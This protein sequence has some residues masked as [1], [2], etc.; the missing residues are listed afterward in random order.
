[1]ESEYRAL[2]SRF[3]GRKNKGC[4][5]LIGGADDARAW[6]FLTGSV[7]PSFSQ[8]LSLALPPLGASISIS[9]SL[10]VQ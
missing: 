1:V 3:T 2:Y 9:G 4:S 5:Q 6:T 7:V 8:L 10:F